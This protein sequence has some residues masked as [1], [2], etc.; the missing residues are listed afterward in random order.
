MLLYSQRTAIP[1]MLLPLSPV[2]ND[3]HR[4][5]HLSSNRDFDLDTSLNVDDDLL[6]NF[7][8]G[9]EI[10]QTLVDSHFESVP[11]LRSFTTRSLSGS[12][13]ESLGW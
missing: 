2:C 8:R 6:D 4:C 9:V 13:L 5:M 7:G 12:D 1:P 11:S 10:N 3:H